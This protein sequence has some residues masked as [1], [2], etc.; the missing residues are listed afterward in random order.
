MRIED[1]IN[2]E[3]A[4]NHTDVMISCNNTDSASQRE[5]RSIMSFGIEL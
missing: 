3:M 2:G 1:N 5:R 4:E